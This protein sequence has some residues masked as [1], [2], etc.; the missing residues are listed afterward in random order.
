M[1]SWGILGASSS[2][3]PFFSLSLSS[4]LSSSLHLV[5]S[6][7]LR[8]FTKARDALSLRSLLPLPAIRLHLP[9]MRPTLLPLKRLSVPPDYRD[10]LQERQRLSAA[11]MKSLLHR[12]AG[13]I[14]T[15][16]AGNLDFVGNWTV[17][18]IQERSIQMI[19]HFHASRSGWMGGGKGEAAC[20]RLCKLDYHQLLTVYRCYLRSRRGR[21]MFAKIYINGLPQIILNSRSHPW[22]FA[23]EVVRHIKVG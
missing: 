11:D 15:V 12:A 20:V 6:R 14:R 23:Q 16:L 13:D 7:L 1:I 10:N 21:R 4:L 8:S 22:N 3:F 5:L 2:P 17:E 9:A 19:V 18:I